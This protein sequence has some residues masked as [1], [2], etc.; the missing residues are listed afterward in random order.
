VSRGCKKHL[1]QAIRWLSETQSA[2]L[3]ELRN[4]QDLRVVHDRMAMVSHWNLPRV[5]ETT[6]ADLD[7]VC[8]SNVAET[9]LKILG[10]YLRRASNQSP[11]HGRRNGQQE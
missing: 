9:Q 5:T 3:E 6:R 11:V 4:L 8:E 2:N 10:E 1:S 7:Q